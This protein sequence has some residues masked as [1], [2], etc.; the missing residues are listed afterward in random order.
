MK[1]TTKKVMV[2][3]T[4]EP[5]TLARVDAAAERLGISRA[6]AISVAIHTHFA[7]IPVP[8]LGGA[9]PPTT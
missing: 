8:D 3:L 1:A 6:A 2:L 4:L 9:L 7:D 5:A